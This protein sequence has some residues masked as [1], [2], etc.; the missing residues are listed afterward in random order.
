M[1]NRLKLL[2][3]LRVLRGVGL[4]VLLLEA[5]GRCALR[6]AL[7]PVSAAAIGVTV[8]GRLEETFED[9]VGGAG[10]DVSTAKAL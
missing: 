7:R 6:P 3:V 4:G 10:A 5:G 8:G 1:L 9:P 2:P